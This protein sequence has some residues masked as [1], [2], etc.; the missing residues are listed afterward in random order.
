MQRELSVEERRGINSEGLWP[1]VVAEFKDQ[2]SFVR[3][4]SH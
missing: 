2:R 1:P 4:N 3:T